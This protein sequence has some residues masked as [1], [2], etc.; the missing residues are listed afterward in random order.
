MGGMLPSIPENC[1]NGRVF[2]PGKARLYCRKGATPYDSQC[3]LCYIGASVVVKDKMVDTKP[4]MSCSNCK[5]AWY[6]SKECKLLLV[7]DEASHFQ[8]IPEFLFVCLHL[9][10]TPAFRLIII[11]LSM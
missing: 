4:L 5:L 10:L 8:E 7:F 6:C 1:P 11:L 2:G 9:S 3:A